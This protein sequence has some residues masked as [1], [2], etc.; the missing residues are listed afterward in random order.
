MKIYFAILLIV[1]SAVLLVSVTPT[2]AQRPNGGPY[3][4]GKSPKPD[5]PRPAAPAIPGKILVVDAAQRQVRVLLYLRVMNPDAPGRVPD[6]MA[7]QA[8]ALSGQA[9]KLED[10]GRA[11]DARRI[12]RHIEELLRW[13]ESEQVVPLDD[14]AMMVGLRRCEFNQVTK[15]TILRVLTVASGDLPASGTPDHVALTRDASQVSENSTPLIRRLPTAPRT[16]TVYYEIIGQVTNNNPLIL[17]VD[18][19]SVQVDTPPQ[20]AAILQTPVTVRDLQPGQRVLA[21]VQLGG[22]GGVQRVKRLLVLLY[23]P[24]TPFGPEEMAD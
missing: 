5:Q 14:H 17:L 2:F 23:R 7:Q 8:A 20:F 13:R 16:R 12:R 10:S 21:R 22:G 19:K 1:L 3:R 15:D 18:D 9:K 6:E 4:G 24:D 11:E